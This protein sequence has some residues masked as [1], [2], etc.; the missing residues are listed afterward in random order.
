[1]NARFAVAIA[2]LL[3]APVALA[4]QAPA[5]ATAPDIPVS[6]RDRV[7]L[8]EQFSNTVSVVDPSTNRHL[9]VI[10]L[11]DSQP[12]KHEPPLPRAGAGARAGVLAR[13]PH[14]GGGVHRFATRSP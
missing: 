13:L 5:A 14:P 2:L 11:G 3:L 12:A 7:Y 9:G 6:A 1:M 8:A 10:K 4:G